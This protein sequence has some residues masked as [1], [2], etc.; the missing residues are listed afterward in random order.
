[1]T[2]AKEKTELVVKKGAGALS[3]FGEMER[4]F[5]EIFHQPF[6]LFGHPMWPRTQFPS[7]E[8]IAPTVDIFEEGKEVAVK[9]EILFAPGSLFLLFH[10]GDN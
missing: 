8:M 10:Y 6:S 2:K 1:M 4:Y 3:P 9:A 5:D 7:R